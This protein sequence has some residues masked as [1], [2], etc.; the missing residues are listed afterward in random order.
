MARVLLVVL[1]P[2]VVL[3]RAVYAADVTY[4][5]NSTD[6]LPDAVPG[7]SKC[8]TSVGY[9]VCTLRAA[10]Q[11]RLGQSD[12]S[13][14][15]MTV[16]LPAGTYRLT[17]TG[18]EDLAASGDLDIRGRVRVLGAG[19]TTTIIDGNGMT[20]AIFDVHW[21]SITHT[22][23]SDL[24][25]THAGLGWSGG[26]SSG[27]I[28]T[29][30]IV[31]GNS[32]GGI[33]TGYP[34][35]I[36]D[37][38]ISNNLGTGVA[39]GSF[40]VKIVNTTV[41][42][43][44]SSSNS[45]GSGIVVFAGVT[46]IN[47]TIS[48][49]QSLTSGGGIRVTGG[50]PANLFNVTL[51][52]NVADSDGTGGS[53]TG[54]GVYG[55]A[56]LYNTI[57]TGNLSNGT[58]DDCSG[59][60][61]A[62][63][64]S[65]ITT[66]VTSHCTVTGSVAQ[67]NP[68]LGPLTDNGGPTLTHALIPN[69]P[70]IDAGFAGG[71]HDPGAALIARDQRGFPRP[72]WSSGRRCDIGAFEQR[73]TAATVDFDADSLGDVLAYR[74]EGGDWSVQATA[75]GG[76]F[77]STSGLW[78]PGWNAAAGRFDADLRTDVF[79]VNPQ[80]GQW[81]VMQSNGSGAFTALA[82]GTWWTGWQ[83]FVVDLNGDGL[84]DVFLWDPASGIW[85]KCLWTGT[86][87]TYVQGSWTPGWEVYPM[88]FS[89]DTLQDFMLYQ[90][91]TG[92][93]FWAIGTAGSSFAIAG[94]PTGFWSTDW[95]FTPADFNGDGYTDVLLINP[96]GFWFTATATPTG[97]TYFTE[98]QFTTGYTP[99]AMPL[100]SDARTDLFMHNP[101]TGQWFE[102]LSNGGGGFTPAGGGTWSLGWSLYPT[103]FDADGLGDMLL[104]NAMTGMWFQARNATGGAF[105]YASGYWS[106][107]LSILASRPY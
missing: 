5:V 24:T 74:P 59:T 1:I 34:L 107:G 77:A 23:I 45:S 15:T 79:L 48:G 64:S 20:E 28:F 103:D 33:I 75:G 17:R 73:F 94:Y 82:S 84:S 106:S 37:S 83:R 2:L 86:G 22:E 80:N 78:T 32:R 65:I 95:T 38:T 92:Q 105:D 55:S 36:Y 25:M 3:Q 9:G 101:A 72:T 26:G 88:R 14:G 18:A 93:W 98:G 43:N 46:A 85:F 10:M 35:E 100:D 6:D 29:R 21:Q 42:F 102:F 12:W 8:E 53:E 68:L 76:T 40:G 19:A 7:D 13:V 89:S 11:E 57:I 54:G 61:S 66:I 56:K 97:F 104:Y 16:V 52:N 81:F 39:G 60:V 49:N 90:R 71:C 87:F 63:D 47:S 50:S 62:P 31:R 99:Y 51:A 4:T 69:S 70:A 91:S 44:V 67:V 58:P 41:A 27:A 96:L 30:V